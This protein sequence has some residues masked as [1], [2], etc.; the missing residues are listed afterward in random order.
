MHLAVCAMLMYLV[1]LQSVHHHSLIGESLMILNLNAMSHIQ[2][3]GLQ[4]TRALMLEKK[5]IRRPARKRRI[6]IKGLVWCCE[7]C[8]MSGEVQV[9]AMTACR[10]EH[11]ISRVGRHAGGTLVPSTM[12][13]LDRPLSLGPEPPQKIFV[14]MT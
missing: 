7:Q 14:L 13:F 2:H 5:C 10:H 3:Q 6:S 1:V 8:D 4:A 9:M 12:C 11:N